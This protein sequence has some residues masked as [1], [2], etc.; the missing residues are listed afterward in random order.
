L[1]GAQSGGKTLAELS[2][3]LHQ[4]I[5]ALCAK[6]DDF[7]NNDHF[8]QALAEYAKA[9]EL[10]PEPK[11]ECDAALWILA[12]IGDAHF[13]SGN[14]EGCRTALMEAAKSCDGA[15]ENPFM[16]LRLGQS[17]FEVGNLGEAANWMGMAFVM[18]GKKLFVNEDPKYLDFIK[19]K[20][21]PPPEGWPEGW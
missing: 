20:F 14:W 9:W 16:R 18:E 8:S 10:L 1:T 2:R 6:G 17:L 11:Q 7:A 13:R 5:D 15:I 12:A 21:Q 3:R 4:Q 19:R